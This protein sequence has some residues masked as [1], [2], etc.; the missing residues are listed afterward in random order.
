MW[1]HRQFFPM[2]HHRAAP[3]AV[4]WPVLNKIAGFCPKT[5][6]FVFTGQKWK[7]NGGEKEGE[8]KRTKKATRKS[9][10]RRLGRGELPLRFPT[11]PLWATS[12]STR[13]LCPGRTFFFGFTWFLWSHDYRGAP[14]MTEQAQKYPLFYTPSGILARFG[15]FNF[16]KMA[17]TALKVCCE[18]LVW[19]LLAQWPPQCGSV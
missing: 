5:F 6:G 4:D 2:V 15:H 13:Y 9:P 10:E 3:T 14:L 7:P 17:R 19:L 1:H 12:A 8:Q 16:R 11:N 18:C